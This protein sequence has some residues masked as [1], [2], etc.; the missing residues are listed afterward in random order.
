M[1]TTRLTRAD[2][3]RMP[4]RNG[5][6]LTTELARHP[7]EGDFDWRVSM[8]DIE[9]DGDFSAFTGYDRSLLLL[10]GQGLSLTF[11]DRDEPVLLH[12]RSKPLVF[13]GDDT[14]HCR[15]IGGPAR[16]FN[17]ITRR[18]RFR[19]ELLLR[20]LVGPMVLFAQ[21][22]TSWI[23]HVL[24]GHASLQRVDDAPTLQAG[25]TLIVHEPEP[26]DR[27]AVI[28]GGGELVLARLTRE[29]AVTGLPELGAP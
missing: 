21:A 12:E 15:L 8:A 22:G 24:S 5:G 25:D 23:I 6:G 9:N 19:H 4:W 20:P 1:R 18:G 29:D 7:S 10:S 27:H 26:E 13:S 16:D 17:V 2:Y 28:G 3:R 14:P 11:A